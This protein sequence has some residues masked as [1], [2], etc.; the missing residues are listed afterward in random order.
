MIFS[1]FFYNDGSQEG[2]G[3]SANDTAVEPQIPELSDDVKA[4]LQELEELRQFKRTIQ[5]KE[6]DKTPEQLAK[7]AEV[8]KAELLKYAVDNEIMKVEDFH[9]FESLKAKADRDLVFEK[10][11]QDWKEENPD[12]S[13]DELSDLAKADFE[14]E[15]KLNSDNEKTKQRG[16][17]KLSKEAAEIRQPLE[18]TYKTA[19]ERFSEEKN[20]RNAVPKFHDFIDQQVNSI[21]DKITMFKTKDNDEEIPIEIE[22]TKEEKEEI[23]NLFKNDKTFYDFISKK[24][25]ELK[26]KLEKK[27]NSVIKEKHFDEVLSKTWE[28]AEKRGVLKGSN[29][30]AENS[31]ALQ[32]GQKKQ[33][34]KPTSLE[35]SN[36][37]AAAVRERMG[38]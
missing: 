37:K 31:F 18:S 1:R 8:E 11:L 26:A 9:K 30:G 32:Q 19:Q 10:Y 22:L 14:A 4:Q 21:S 23:A 29:V 28:V 17:S 13:E 15:Y 12:V 33:E 7:E 16:L 2:G 35:E 34:I 24:P 20:I 25:E 36:K 27:I 38:Y 6:P 3:A 5:E